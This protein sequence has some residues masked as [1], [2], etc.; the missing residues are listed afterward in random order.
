MVVNILSAVQRFRLHVYHRPRPIALDWSDHWH[1][2]TN[3]A[4]PSCPQTSTAP[5]P[6]QLLLDEFL[7]LL[8]LGEFADT[9]D[10]SHAAVRSLFFNA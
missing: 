10:Y 6:L 9:Q 8:P 3:A 2:I 1:A 4:V 5:R 7:L